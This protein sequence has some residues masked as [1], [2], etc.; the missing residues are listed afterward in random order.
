MGIGVSTGSS[1]ANGCDTVIVAKGAS[2]DTALADELI[3]AGRILAGSRVDLV[4]SGVSVAVRAGAPLPDIGTEDALR[5]AVLESGS[6]AYSTGPSGVHLLQVQGR[7]E[8]TVPLKDLRET[9]RQ[10][11]RD[12]KAQVQY[13]RWL[14]ELKSRAYIELRET[15]S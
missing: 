11:L 15:G 6:L 14:A 12:K 13:E 5:R 10:L 2:G 1:P 9:G 7:R 3:A 4:R 8:V